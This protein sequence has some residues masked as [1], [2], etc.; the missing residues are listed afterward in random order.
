MVKT[1]SVRGHSLARLAMVLVSLSLGNIPAVRV[2]MFQ[3][4]G[5]PSPV[6]GRWDSKSIYLRSSYH[7]ALWKY[8]FLH[9][10]LFRGRSSSLS[11]ITKKTCKTDPSPKLWRQIELHFFITF[12]CSYSGNIKF[13]NEL[14]YKCGTFSYQEGFSNEKHVQASLRP[15]K[16]RCPWNGSDCRTSMSSQR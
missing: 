2:I 4:G 7:A 15:K 9:Q 3:T 1:I 6:F 5:K 11:E 12:E 16:A 13:D 14:D 10:W 8:C